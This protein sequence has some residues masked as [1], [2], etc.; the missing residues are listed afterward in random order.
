M[1][2]NSKS[3]AT[4]RLSLT[5]DVAHWGLPFGISKI[6]TVNADSFL[7][8]YITL[9]FLCFDLYYEMWRIKVSAL[10]QKANLVITEFVSSKEWKD[11]HLFEDFSDER[12]WAI[13]RQVNDKLMSLVPTVR[14][15]DC[16]L[17]K[18]HQIQFTLKEFD[19]VDCGNTGLPCDGCNQFHPSNVMCPPHE[20]RTTGVAALT[21]KCFCG[22]ERPD[23]KN[24]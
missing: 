19:C 23:L 2:W 8:K 10:V 16:K 6:Y 24:Q 9:S 11:E 18:G 15:V 4:H 20:V 5:V 12:K 3:G 1:R 13:V 22:R 14:V 17:G 7:Q 21:M